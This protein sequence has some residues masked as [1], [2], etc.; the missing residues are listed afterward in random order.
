[1]GPSGFTASGQGPSKDESVDRRFTAPFRPAGR[2]HRNLNPG[3]PLSR[4]RTA[5][6]TSAVEIAKL[7][8]HVNFATAL[9]ESGREIGPI[10][11]APTPTSVNQGVKAK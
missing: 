8:C 7:R 1:M 3:V 9:A 6:P 4:L 2:E 5:L 11:R 10:R